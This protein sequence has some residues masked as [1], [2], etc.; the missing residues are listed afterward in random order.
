MKIYMSHP[1]RRAP[2]TINTKRERAYLTWALLFS[3]RINARTTQ[4]R[5]A[6]T[7][8]ERM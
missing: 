7:T 4:T 5:R 3:L 6:Y 1:K 8:I 2:T